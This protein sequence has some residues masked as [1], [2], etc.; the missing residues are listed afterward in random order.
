MTYIPL[1]KINDA[2]GSPEADNFV[3]VTEI[4]NDIIFDK[5]I[6][7]NTLLSFGV[8]ASLSDDLITLINKII[9]L[10]INYVENFSD[11]FPDH[12]ATFTGNADSVV[13]TLLTGITIPSISNPT[14]SEFFADAT[15]SF[16]GDLDSG[17]VYLGGDATDTT[18]SILFAVIDVI[19]GVTLQI[20]STAGMSFADVLVQ[21]IYTTSIVNIIDS[22]HLIVGDTTGWV[23]STLVTTF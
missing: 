10:S 13:V 9:P 15:A 7:V 5:T 1:K 6:L 3:T 4:A 8:P 2:I 22:T 21:G 20:D 12:S 23:A 19:D 16:T 11:F 14:L 18:K 17:D